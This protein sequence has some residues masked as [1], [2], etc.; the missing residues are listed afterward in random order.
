VLIE[1]APGHPSQLSPVGEM[2]GFLPL[3]LY[4]SE[5]AVRAAVK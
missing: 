1:A 2:P 4:I 5:Q 3:A